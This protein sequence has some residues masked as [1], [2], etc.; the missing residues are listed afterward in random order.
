MRNSGP[1]AGFLLLDG[2]VPGGTEPSRP[3]V[4]RERDGDLLQPLS[5]PWLSVAVVG[6]HVEGSALEQARLAQ[7]G[8]ERLGGGDDTDLEVAR[9]QMRAQPALD[10][11]LGPAPTAPGDAPPLITRAL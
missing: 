11:R 4:H 8:L 6:H 3:A 7:P 9:A 2:T 5:W 10:V 1:R